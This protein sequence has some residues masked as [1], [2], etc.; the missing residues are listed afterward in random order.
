VSYF[1][2]FSQA[3]NHATNNTLLLLR[4]F[5][6]SSPVKIQRALTEI[7][8][9]DL[10]IGL[11]FQQQIRGGFSVPDGLITQE[12]LRIF[13]ETKRGGNLDADQIKRHLQSISKNSTR[14]GDI[15]IGLTKERIAE[16]DRKKL[17]EKATAHGIAFAAM[18]F[19]Q[20]A[21]VLRGLCAPHESELLAIIEDYES[22]LSAE[23]LMEERDKWLVVFPC[24]ET[25]AKN[26]RFGLYFEPSSRLCK[27]CCFIGLYKQKVVAYIGKVEAIAVVSFIGS[28]V[29]FVQEEGTL[30]DEH[31]RRIKE[32][33]DLKN[34]P[35]RY[36]LVD[37]FA[38]TDL[39]KTSPGSIMGFRY[40][41]LSKLL[42]SFNP[43]RDYST[44][45]MAAALKGG[46]W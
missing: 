15:L 5:Y 9:T 39:K 27:R 37:H 34:V 21:E 20:I 43:R 23:G 6:Q 14:G 8:E 40:L 22:Y 32:V 25:I 11:S 19:S 4:Y 24:G 17:G 35:H 10:S 16:T 41:D 7:I 2:R 46:T 36:Y 29:D 12:A 3:E 38:G 33:A 44:D 13:L 26:A 45:E 31:R 30:T 42:P 18:T 1:Q 28:D